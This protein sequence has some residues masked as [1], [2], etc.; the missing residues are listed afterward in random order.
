[1][2]TDYQP[3]I[4][5]EVHAQLGTL[6]KL[7][8]GS[9]TEFGARP[10]SS[11]SP[12][13][14]G[15]PGSLPV[16]NRRAV[17]MAVR[18]AL[19][20]NCTVHRHSLF[21]RKNYFYPDLPKG[22]QISQFEE[23]FSTDGWLEFELE[24]RQQR[25]GIIRVHLE[26][27][28][29]KNVHGVGGDSLVDL[30]RAGVPLIEIVGAPDL[31]SSAEAAAYLRALREILMFIG[32]NDGNLEEGS[33]RCD[34]NV[35]VRPR[36]ESALGTRCELK[37]LNSF[38]FV[39]RAIDAEV[40]R[41]VAVLD[42]GGVIEQETR[43]FDPDTGQTSTLRSKED[44]HD[45]RYFPEPDLPPLE[46]SDELVAE[47]RSLAGELPA[48]TRKRWMETLG[49]TPAAAATLTQHP[50]VARFFES[51][52][53]LCPDPVAA[54]NWIQ[55]EVL[56]GTELKGLGARFPVTPQQVAE[57]LGLVGAGQISGK[58]AKEVFGAIEGTDRSPRAVVEERGIRVVSDEPSLRELCR[59]LVE[60]HPKE[61]ALVRGGKQGVLGFFVGQVMKQTGGA[62]DPKLVSRILGELLRGG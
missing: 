60:S 32:I 17:E 26:E 9:S 52:I 30:N 36:E 38:R 12:V 33:F 3:V 1:V 51:T 19:A 8:C 45:Y 46:L 10:N 62:A 20:L 55:T 13:V 25:A 29:G 15:L 6:S 57:L 34:A 35:S 27:D 40:A 22:Y 2:A 53:A 21:A 4:G 37:N 23:P 14:L 44:A 16:L 59:A 47:Q 49:L 28:A 7:F 61:A 48:R 56:R 42:A 31:G 50:A 41:Q 54:A 5:L 43:A 24:G 58:Q 39:Q 11:V 18:A